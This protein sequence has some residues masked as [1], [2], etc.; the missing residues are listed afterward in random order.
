MEPYGCRD[1]RRW[2]ERENHKKKKASCRTTR[3]SLKLG[4]YVDRSERWGA[5]RRQAHGIGLSTSS[6]CL[7]AAYIAEIA[8][9]LAVRNAYQF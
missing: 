7:V 1:L 8:G 6:G 5:G 3:R 9:G 4:D 2:G